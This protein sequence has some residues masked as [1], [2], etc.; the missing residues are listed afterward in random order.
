MDRS[1]IDPYFHILEIS[2]DASLTEI[3]TAYMYLKKLYS[4]E[5]IATQPVSDELYELD[6]KIILEEIETA[7]NKIISY[8]QADTGETGADNNSA[9]STRSEADNSHPTCFSGNVIKKIREALGVKLYEVASHTK[10]GR[11]HLGNIENEQFEQLPAEVFL[12]GYLRTFAKY[13]SLDSE[14]VV[15]DYMKEYRQWKDNKTK[16]PEVYRKHKAAGLL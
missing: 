3:R 9:E 7:Y 2:P 4:K 16:Q 12:K 1:K 5:S 11:Q 15:N 6:N 14:K 8:L 13:L 10:I